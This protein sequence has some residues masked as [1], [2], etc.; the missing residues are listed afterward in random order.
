MTREPSF[1]ASWGES[2]GQREQREEMDRHL[3][4]PGLLG[5]LYVVSYTFGAM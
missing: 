2:P 4:V 3:T 1:E 5:K